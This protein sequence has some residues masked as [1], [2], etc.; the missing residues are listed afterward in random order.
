MPDSPSAPDFSI[1]GDTWTAQEAE[2][3]K[4]LQGPIWV[5]GGS[6]FIGAKLFFSLSRI[7]SDVY[8]V[9]KEIEISW[10]LLNFPSKNRIS[11]DIT[12]REEVSRAVKAWRPKTVFN[13]S[14][15]GGYERQDNR[16]NI[17]RVNY[18]GTLNL[19]TALMESGCEAFVMAGSSSE[20][21]RNCAGPRETDPIEP[22]SDYAVS[23]AA[24]ASLLQFY[25]KFESF[26]SAHLR[27]YS[28]YG[29]WEERDRLIPRLVTL[30]LQGQLIPLVDANITRDFVYVDDCTRAFVRAALVSCRR[31]PGSIYNIGTG[32]KTSLAEVAAVARERMQI[33]SEPHFG[34]MTNRKWDLDNWYGNPEKA[35]TGL[36]WSPKT[37]FSAGLD[38]TIA[39]E[40]S[41]AGAVRFNSSPLR[42]QKISAIVACYKD[43]LAVPHMYERL[44][45]TF[46]KIG[47]DYEI[48]FVN[49]CSPTGDE[50]EIR[51]ICQ[52][53][54]RV[55]G[56][57]H[58]RNFGSQ[59]A[60]AS[61]LELSTGDA[62]VLLDGDLQDP[63]ELIE[64]FVEKWREGYDIVYGVRIKREAAW[65]MQVLYKL[66]YRV[67]KNLSDIQMPIDAGD[68]SL[69][70]RKAVDQLLRFP[71]R[72]AF[73]RGLRAWIGFKQIGVEYARPERTFGKSTNSLV[74][75]FWWAKK[76]IFS[77]SL[78][79]LYYIQGIG[80]AI[81]GLSAALTLF[82]LLNYFFRPETRAPGI[83]TI[84]LLILGVGGIQIFSLS[85][86]GD[87]IGKILEEAKA[88]PKFIRSK[89]LIGNEVVNSPR[90]IS[91]FA[92]ERESIKRGSLS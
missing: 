25:G 81:F 34:S 57:S 10:R 37:S 18:I 85:I 28:V 60:F 39:W 11:L 47:L 88:R 7:R 51:H 67:F 68:F 19:V 53:D 22:N 33:T 80:L 3:A 92:A 9:S 35:R 70:N 56:I 63:P 48:I 8:A 90:E 23:K 50:E 12:D 87:Y 74:K 61:G 20:Y 78:K 45:Q 41:A 65:H 89:L 40:R 91:R 17:H 6:G 14:A 62:A 30:G 77:F 29:P 43:N 79:P 73:L 21:G 2:E 75:N 59:S 26:P 13:L 24:C 44:K 5:V 49:D 72:D 16:A 1:Y 64:A 27:L 4:S 66:F 46:A 36:N 82:Y 83:T 71:E 38:L 54:A 32:V 69:M 15:Y 86:I 76:A 52:Q 42:K 55:L 84:I 31:Q 58:S